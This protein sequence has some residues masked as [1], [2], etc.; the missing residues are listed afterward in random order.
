[1]RRF[2]PTLTLE[3]LYAVLSVAAEDGPVSYDRLAELCEASY[4]TVGNHAA[5][6]S[7]G[8]GKQ[9]GA[10]LLVRT[11]GDDRRAKT[12][13]LSRAGRAV[14][15]LFA[16]VSD[17][18]TSSTETLR[19]R[20][21]PALRLVLKKEPDLNLTAF[22]AL[23]YITQHN[24]LF[25]HQGI[26]AATIAQ[27]LGI[28]NLP[29][30]LARLSGEAGCGLIELTT[31]PQDRRITLPAPSNAGLSLVTSVAGALLGRLP[32][33][34][35]RPKPESLLRAE[36]PE[37]VRTFSDQDFDIVD[38]DEIDWGEPSDK[39]RDTGDQA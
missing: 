29:R 18:R 4:G 23:L 22:S 35:R 13:V 25:A 8:R 21:L 1:M 26:P 38:F 24:M 36:S 20:V 28:S 34:V 5:L 30:I 9:P 27:A 14:A 10:R 3:G 32:S 19:N 33:P 7:D 11:R 2:R 17:D 15:G 16:S 39:D 37:T 6:L 12:L 31:N